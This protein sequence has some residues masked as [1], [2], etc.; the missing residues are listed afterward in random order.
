M[1]VPGRGWTL[2]ETSAGI[3]VVVVNLAGRVFTGVPAPTNL[4]IPPY[5][6]VND[7]T[8]VIGSDTGSA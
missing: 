7:S 8:I 3:P 1:G 2:A 5:R 6:F 4:T